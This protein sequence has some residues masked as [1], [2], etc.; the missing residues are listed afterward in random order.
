MTEISPNV[1][2][3]REVRSNWN[4]H[5]YRNPDSATDENGLNLLAP[6]ADK[7]RGDA[8]DLF[9]HLLSTHR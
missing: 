9:S 6:S 5:R 4:W 2:T 3:A 8:Y 7:P 1:T